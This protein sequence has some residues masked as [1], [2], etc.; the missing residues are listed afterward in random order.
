MF[1]LSTN[2]KKKQKMHL[3]ECSNLTWVS[4]QVLITFSWYKILSFDITRNI[5]YCQNEVRLLTNTCINTKN[6]KNLVVV[7]FIR[8]CEYDSQ[9]LKPKQMRL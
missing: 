7:L 3:T 9:V 4:Y 1:I 2:I 8:D 6:M 5:Q